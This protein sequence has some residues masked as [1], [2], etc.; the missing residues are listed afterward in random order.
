[1]PPDTVGQ[2]KSADTQQAGQDNH[3][4]GGGGKPPDAASKREPGQKKLLDAEK[5]NHYRG[6]TWYRGGYGRMV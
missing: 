3:G 2:S 6:R 5:D 1:M 4:G